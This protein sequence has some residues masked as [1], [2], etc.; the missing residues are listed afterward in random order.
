[1]QDILHETLL[2]VISHCSTISGMAIHPNPSN[3]GTPLHNLSYQSHPFGE[4]LLLSMEA[5]EQKQLEQG[6]SSMAHS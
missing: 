5:Q 6:M 2:F 4:R 3:L 1:M